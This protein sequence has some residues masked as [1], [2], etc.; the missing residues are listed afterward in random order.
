MQTI[1]I[2]TTYD[3]WIIAIWT[4]LDYKDLQTIAIWTTYDVSTIAVSTTSQID[5]TVIWTTS[6]KTVLLD[7]LF[8]LQ[9]FY[10]FMDLT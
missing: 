10:S 9:S 3:V 7:S 8:S 4:V 2:W 1:A 5:Y 6:V